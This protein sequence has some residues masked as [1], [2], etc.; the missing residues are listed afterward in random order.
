MLYIEM[1]CAVDYTEMRTEELGCYLY[2][3]MFHTWC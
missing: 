3:V 2:E 1:I